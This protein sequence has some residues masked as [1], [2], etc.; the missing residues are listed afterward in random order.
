[1]LCL[2]PQT[3]L[4]V[5]GELNPR[6]LSALDLRGPAVGFT[7]FLEAVPFPK[8]RSATRQAL[9][10]SDLQA[11]ERD[12]AFVLDAGVEAEAVLRAARGAD[13]ALIE[14]VSVFDVF[15]G[16]RAAGQFGEGK[17]SLAIAVRLQPTRA[18]LTEAG[19]EAVSARIVA[20]VEK[21]TGGVLR[22]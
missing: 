14:A 21:A 6:V 2:G 5:F 16:E 11:V 4:G 3:V 18:T 22:Q 9:A 7:L 8:A 12:F 13:K 20:A 19:I 17:K 10:L 1:M 15:A